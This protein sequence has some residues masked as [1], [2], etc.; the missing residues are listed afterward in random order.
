MS[1][2]A[3]DLNNRYDPS[4]L[5]SSAADSA[6]KTDSEKASSNGSVECVSVSPETGAHST[7]QFPIFTTKTITVEMPLSPS[8]RL[9]DSHHGKGFEQSPPGSSSPRSKADLTAPTVDWKTLPLPSRDIAVSSDF[10]SPATWR[11]QMDKPSSAEIMRLQRLNASE[12]Q[13]H[14]DVE[15]EAEGQIEESGQALPPPPGTACAGGCA[16]M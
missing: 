4:I 11:T 1:P 16:I 9:N 10:N 13:L 5:V 15:E 14:V 7:L 3:T 8:A 2:P 6:V 12:V